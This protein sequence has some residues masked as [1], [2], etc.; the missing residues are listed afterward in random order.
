MTG[1]SVK[2]AESSKELSAKERLVIKDTTDCIKLDE[3]TQKGAVVIDVDYYAIL[4]IHND[5]AEDKDYQ[6]IVIADKDGNKY[7]TGSTSFITSFVDIYDEMRGE[8][9]TQWAAKCY[10]VPSKNYKGKEFL[11][12]SIV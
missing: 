4:D 12:C 9:D 7:S 11:T 3:A 8:V 5:K 10:R 2:V 6:N 1:Y